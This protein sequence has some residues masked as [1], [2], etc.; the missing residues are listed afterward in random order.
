MRYLRNKK[1]TGPEMCPAIVCG[2]V[3]GDSPVSYLSIVFP[4]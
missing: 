2:I 4:S 1:G 3:T